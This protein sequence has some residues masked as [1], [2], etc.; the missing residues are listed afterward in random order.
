VCSAVPTDLFRPSRHHVCPAVHT[1]LSRPSRRHVC[2]TLRDRSYGNFVHLCSSHAVMKFSPLSNSSVSNSQSPSLC[3]HLCFISRVTCFP[4]SA[5]PLPFC[6]R[7][8]DRH[9]YNILWLRPHSYTWFCSCHLKRSIQSRI[10]MSAVRWIYS[11]HKW[12]ERDCS[13]L[14]WTPFLQTK[15]RTV[16]CVFVAHAQ[17]IYL[18]QLISL[19][20]S[21]SHIIDGITNSKHSP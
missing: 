13:L 17:V 12:R 14:R 16:L 15:W 8:F 10:P 4:Y 3:V 18:L 5:R 7:H 20:L 11:T 1:E 2:S 6:A 21:L 9:A 19:S